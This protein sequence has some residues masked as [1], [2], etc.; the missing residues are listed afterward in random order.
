MDASVDLAARVAL[1]TA[2]ALVAFPAAA[3]ALGRHKPK[4]ARDGAL[5]AGVFLALL[6]AETAVMLALAPV[7]FLTAAYLTAAAAAVVL[8]AA[9]LLRAAGLLAVAVVLKYVISIIFVQAWR[10][11]VQ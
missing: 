8:V 7:W 9:G 1:R 2:A 4:K 11:L 6:A 5:A 3:L 10:L